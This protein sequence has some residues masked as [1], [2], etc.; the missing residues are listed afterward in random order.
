MSDF[1][2]SIF[3]HIDRVMAQVE[4]NTHVHDM[5]ILVRQ[6]AVA[7]ATSEASKRR[8]IEQTVIRGPL[9]DRPNKMP[10]R[11]VYDANGDGTYVMSNGR[12]LRTDPP[13]TLAEKPFPKIVDERARIAQYI[14]QRIHRDGCDLHSVR[15]IIRCIRDG[16]FL[17]LHSHDQLDGQECA[18]CGK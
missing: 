11:V 16:S 9:S 2:M 15:N 14:I 1:S 8:A 17:E 5:L 4:P 7:G 10:E 12:W 3:D 6:I 18:V 13:L